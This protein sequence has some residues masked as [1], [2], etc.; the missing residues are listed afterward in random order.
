MNYP[1]FDTPEAYVEHL[2]QLRR[3]IDI[4]N[5]DLPRI[6]EKRFGLRMLG[7]SEDQID[8][9]CRPTEINREEVMQAV[10]EAS[11]QHQKELRKENRRPR[12]KTNKQ[13]QM[14]ML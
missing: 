14:V 9:I 1:T 13:D 10:R 12:K 11:I 4:S 5:N 6:A 3:Y 7:Y 2:Q 8:D